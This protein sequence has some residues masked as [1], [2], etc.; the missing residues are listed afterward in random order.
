MSERE[1]PTESSREAQIKTL[2]WVHFSLCEWRSSGGEPRRASVRPQF[3]ETGAQS[4]ST[5][6]KVVLLQNLKMQFVRLED[7]GI[8]KS[9]FTEK[10]Q[11]KK[12][13]TL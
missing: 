8:N 7:A 13:K 12:T 9:H 3:E 5:G 11:S 2:G 10:P 4:P 1:M 6:L